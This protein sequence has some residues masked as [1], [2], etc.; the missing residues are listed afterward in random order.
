MGL[1]DACACAC[2]TWHGLHACIYLACMSVCLPAWQGM[3]ARI[4]HACVHACP[5]TRM[6]ACFPAI[7]ACFPATHA[8]MHVAKEHVLSLHSHPTRAGIGENSPLVRG[9]VCAGLERMGVAIDEDANLQYTGGKAGIISKPESK[10][11]VR[12]M[13]FPRGSSRG[14]GAAGRGEVQGSGGWGR[15]GALGGA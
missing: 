15:G 4:T 10:V 5:P 7:N 14:R 13:R 11:K 8:C 9:L 6:H 1:S 3:N 2:M 12:V